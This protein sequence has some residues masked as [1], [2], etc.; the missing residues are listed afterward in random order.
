MIKLK[1]EKLEILIVSNLSIQKIEVE[2][3]VTINNLD[4]KRIFGFA[5]KL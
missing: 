2:S 4:V 1:R 3:Q 5:L